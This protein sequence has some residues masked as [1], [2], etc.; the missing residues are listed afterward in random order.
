MADSDVTY[1]FFQRESTADREDLELSPTIQSARV[2]RHGPATSK[3]RSGS[4]PPIQFRAGSIAPQRA[5]SI[6]PQR[7]GS[8]AP[9]RAGSIAP[10]RASSILRGSSF[11]PAPLRSASVA[12]LGSSYGG[13]SSTYRSTASYRTPAG[14]GN[15]VMGVR[16]DGTMGPINAVAARRRA[17][18]SVT[19][20]AAY[21]PRTSVSVISTAG[22]TTNHNRN[23]IFRAED[24]Q[25]SDGIKLSSSAVTDG[26]LFRRSTTVPPPAATSYKRVSTSVSAAPS[27]VY[28]A[29]I[30]RSGGTVTTTTVTSKPAEPAEEETITYRRTRP[31]FEKERESLAFLRQRTN[32]ARDQLSRHRVLLDRYLPLHLG[33]SNDVQF[34]VEDKVNELY[35]RMPYLDPTRPRNFERDYGNYGDDTPPR[36][37]VI[38]PYQPVQRPPKVELPPPF[39][40]KPM[41]TPKISDVRKRARS[42][43]CKV[44]GDPHYFD[45]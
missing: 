43:L 16:S 44:K 7:A 10:Q 41:F 13:S 4:M 32:K 15:V 8:I 2:I 18:I 37:L 35:P 6:A 21:R 22:P 1:L 17:S 20:S 38:Q 28:R 40:Y 33:P 29:Y 23:Q 30:P 14:A 3:L 34:N 31:D 5:G 42:V 19:P 36:P 11:V 9:Q 27:G 12:P 26:P 25:L 45:F 39:P 24:F